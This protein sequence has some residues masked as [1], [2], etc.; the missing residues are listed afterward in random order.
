MAETDTGVQESNAN[1]PFAGINPDDVMNLI[2][3]T[4]TEIDD[5]NANGE[6]TPDENTPSIETPLQPA[7]TGVTKDELLDV[8]KTT[9]AAGIQVG[10]GTQ[11]N[12]QDAGDF[13]ETY[14]AGLIKDYMSS[15]GLDEKGAEFLASTNM[16]AIKPL[17]ALMAQGFK[18]VNNR[19]TDLDNKSILVEVDQNLNSWL[20]GKNVKDAQRRQDII[21][22]AKA[23]ASQVPDADMNTLRV[24]F[25]KVS[26]RFV[27]EEQ[28][29]E[30]GIIAQAEENNSLPPVTSSGKIGFEDV[31]ARVRNSTDRKDDIGGERFTALAERMIAGGGI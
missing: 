31:V 24:E 12:P 1:D 13:L 16:A 9:L 30:D 4:V 28:A 25:E 10:T 6:Q 17:L 7:Q 20:D 23:N 5:M 21:T 27:E 26:A 22:I 3:G 18:Q 8:V 15:Q 11:A 29:E 19:S 14:K 2:S